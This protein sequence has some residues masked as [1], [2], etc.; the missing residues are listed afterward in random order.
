MISPRH[1]TLRQLLD[2]WQRLKRDRSMPRKRE[3]DPIDLP[4]PVLPR[5]FLIEFLGGAAN[6]RLRLMGTYLR[7]L[8]G[9]SSLGAGSSTTRCPA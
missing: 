1:A 5:L 4:L 8:T 2:Y 9:A 3:F 6:Y 7:T